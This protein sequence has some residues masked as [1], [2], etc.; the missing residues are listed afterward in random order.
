M[1]E[2]VN[3]M[4]RDEVGAAVAYTYSD[5]NPRNLVGQ[6]QI[7]PEEERR[8]PND[9]GILWDE[10]V[11]ARLGELLGAS[12]SPAPVNELRLEIGTRHFLNVPME[13]AEATVARLA[14]LGFD[15]VCLDAERA[16]GHVDL[17]VFDDADACSPSPRT[18]VVEKKL[19]EVA[20]SA[21]GAYDG[22]ESQV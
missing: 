3:S 12:P 18:V 9:D 10:N 20:E 8:L 15:K 2:F 4:A 19:S 17:V 14:R 13:A 6:R 1:P 5:A 7:S 16:D 21:G 22:R 11:E